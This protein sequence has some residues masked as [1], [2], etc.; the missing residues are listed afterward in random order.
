LSTVQKQ[1]DL[2]QINERIY[3]LKSFSEEDMFRFKSICRKIRPLMNITDF[4][5]AR[6]NEVLSRESFTK[7][8]RTVVD[9]EEKQIQVLNQ[10]LKEAILKELCG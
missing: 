7:P 2:I 3:D 10:A 6:P 1:Y 5:R 8:H 4:R 9:F